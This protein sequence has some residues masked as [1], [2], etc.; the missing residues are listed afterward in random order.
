MIVVGA[1][2]TLIGVPEEPSPPAYLAKIPS[3]KVREHNENALLLETSEEIVRIYAHGDSLDFRRTVGSNHRLFDRRSSE[4]ENLNEQLQAMFA[5]ADSQTTRLSE[6]RAEQKRL[7]DNWSDEHG[8]WQSRMAC[9]QGFQLAAV[10]YIPTVLVV[11]VI[12]SS[13]GPQISASVAKLIWFN[14]SEL[15]P[16]YMAL[17]CGT[18]VSSVVGLLSG[19]SLRSNLAAQ[20]RLQSSSWLREQADA[21]SGTE[22]EGG[23]A[24]TSR[25]SGN[26]SGNFRRDRARFNESGQKQESQT[27]AEPQRKQW[28]EILG[29]RQN[30]TRAEIEAAWRAKV[31]SNHP[32]LTGRLDP[33]F[34]KLAEQRT[35]DINAA[36]DEGLR[37]C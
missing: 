23:K 18:I 8:S 24:K 12:P 4:A 5:R 7:M 36:R 27:S 32:D 25:R 10:A 1:I 14:V 31:R 6:L 2:L 16:Y 21:I 22:N 37:Q 13:L 20:G 19:F 15:R 17:T 35:Q 26:R 33:E 29:V 34:Q 3:I 28:S 30:A 11:A 9:R